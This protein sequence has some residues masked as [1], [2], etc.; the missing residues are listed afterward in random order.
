MNLVAYLLPDDWFG[1]LNDVRSPGFTGVF[2]DGEYAKF[3]SMGNGTTF[4][5]ETLIFASLCYAVGAKQYLVYGDDIVIDKAFY[6]PLVDLL[7]DAGFQINRKKS[8]S[9]GP[10]RESCGGNYHSGFDITPF[11][12]RRTPRCKAEWCH[13]VNGLAGV[14]RPGGNLS[15]LL[16]DIVLQER[17]PMGPY[18]TSTTCWVHLDAST[19]YREG[20]IKSDRHTFGCRVR[21]YVARPQKRSS[22]WSFRLRKYYLWHFR[23]L[24]TSGFDDDSVFSP[25]VALLGR[26]ISD[27]TFRYED[28]FIRLPVQTS[29]EPITRAPEGYKV[30]WVSW[31]PPASETPAHL[32]WWSDWLVRVS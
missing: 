31:F 7:G 8:F 6:Q 16:K 1:F 23:R 20:V 19:A 21:G 25:P 10:F 18:A 9:E 30:K 4:V 13:I 28:P 5:L 3:S 27:G 26:F 17:L 11:Y 12:W 29:R 32:Y 15:R 2:G 14:A 24:A 22:S